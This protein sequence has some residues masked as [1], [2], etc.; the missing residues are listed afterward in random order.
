MR[1][2]IVEDEII[3]N[4]IIGKHLQAEGFMVD[5]CYDGEEALE[6]IR[7][8]QYDAILLDIMLPKKNGYEILQI[9]RRNHD[10]TPVIALTALTETPDVIRGLDFGADDYIKKPF[11]FDELMARI[12]VVVRRN[13]GR[14]DNIYRCGDLTLDSKSHMV[15][16]G[17]Q[18]LTLTPKEYALLELL[19][20]NKNIVLS[21]D[22]IASN[23]W[24]IDFDA[25]S[26]VIDVYIRYLRRK[27]D[28]GY[29]Q[30]LI[31][32]VRGVGYTIRCDQ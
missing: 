20:H 17:D 3:L 1:I 30:K 11:D 8:I 13:T 28:E 32:T 18:V 12:R 31:H 25:E 5:C 16:R 9:M 6:Y 14:A 2:L 24:D 15:K 4:R 26:N 23:L 10:D 22:Q 21:R 29:E 19:I 7:T 27:I